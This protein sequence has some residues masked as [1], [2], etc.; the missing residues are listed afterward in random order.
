VDVV[1]FSKGYIYFRIVRM[2]IVINKRG[3][4]KV[5]GREIRDGNLVEKGGKWIVH[6]SPL[7]WVV[8]TYLL[9]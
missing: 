2:N 8:P 9:R 7:T 5:A 3:N 6:Y 1:T 4:D